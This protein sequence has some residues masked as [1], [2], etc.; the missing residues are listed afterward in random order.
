MKI[1]FTL[2]MFFVLCFVSL[3]A[4][5][6]EIDFSFQD[7]NLSLDKRVEILVS[8]MTTDE[9]I[10]QLR[11]GAPEIE[12][13]KVPDYDWWNEALHGV[14]R[15]GK[16]TIFPQG[17]GV[18][19][20]FDPE[21]AERVASAI[22][23][24]ARAKYIIS[25]KHGNHSKYAG[26]TFWTPNVNIFRDPRW[27]RG[28]E[29]Y[30]EDPFLTSKIGVAFVKG[31]QGNDPNYLKSA[32]CAKHYAVHSGPESI[33]HHF[34][35]EPT[36]QDLYETY[37]PAFE[38]LVVE[39]KVEGVMTA[40]NA[41][42]GVPAGA[43]KFLIQDILIDDWNFDGYVTSD[44]GAVSGISNKLKYVKTA[45]EGASVALKVGMNLNCGGAFSQLKKAV[46][47]GLV[48]EEL[49][50]ERTKQ[51][52]KTRFR[53]G[54]FDK[55]DN[56]PYTK[57]G[58]ENI[59]SKEH[60]SLA[61]EAAQ[62][63]IVLLKNTNNTLP[64]SKE[65]KVP[66]VTGPF[67]NSADVLMG[68]YYGVSPG[69][70]T[71]LAGITDAVSLSSS[72][73]YRSGA[74]PFHKNIN[75]KNWAPNVAAESDVTICVVGLSA[76]REGEEVD[77]IAALNVG[78]KID[79]KLPENQIN[80]V[81]QIAKVKKGPLVLVIAS[82]SPV[83]LEGIE[84][85]CDAILQIWYPGEQGGNAVA[86]ILFGDISPSGHLPITFPKNV[87][88]LPSYEDYSMQGRTYKYMTKEPMFPFG[89]GLTYSKTTLKNLTVSDKK[90][91]KDEK[92]EVTVDVTNTGNCDID[93][94]VQLYVSPINNKEN[95]PITSL[96]AFKRI[97]LAK[98]SSKKVSFSIDADDLKVINKKGEKV[99]YKG[100][101]KLIVGNSS[102]GKLSEKLGAAMPQEAIITLK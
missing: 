21:L 24:E 35:A 80:Y 99:W 47:N 88:Q 74:L 96:K 68:S 7:T 81:K 8:Q 37:L 84:E 48:S 89:F 43:S 2:T 40:Y 14:A 83:S 29:T 67:A 52:F 31:L 6:K 70:V 41:V 61:R 30:G 26:L 11:N 87:A 94:V 92:L 60:I 42:Y 44:C 93:E 19:A 49:I 78:D 33:R 73:N 54:M 15:N 65:I 75:P 36:K 46:K 5:N 22:S 97:A 3:K 64:L 95:L 102:P 32:A 16:A 76:D 63:S 18:G 23:T 77:A 34:N 1:K 25:Q 58:S 90:L 71:V 100:D 9:K 12:R 45:E 28:Q 72:L 55:V 39:G 69:I 51:L 98:G 59:H 4:Q 53:L 50:H 101:Y 13:L 62:K 56:N 57:L 27:G 38:A 10:D 86:D 91:K 85:Y 66:Y 20:T 79:L 82:G 17:I